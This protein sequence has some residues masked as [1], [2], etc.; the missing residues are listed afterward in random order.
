[1]PKNNIEEMDVQK[2]KEN[3]N[4]ELN[5]KR[6][7][8]EKQSK[9]P[10][11]KVQNVSNFPTSSYTFFC[12]SFGLLI[13]G[14]QATG[15]CEYGST[16]VNSVMLF[17]GICQ[18]ILGIFDW[19]QKKNILSMQNIIFGIYFISYFF[20][21]FEINGIKKS[22]VMYSYMQGL[23]DLIMLFFVSMVIL[24]IKGKGICYIIDYF[25]LFFCFACLALCGYSNDESIVI[26][27]SGYIWFISF[28]FFWITGLGLIINDTFNK[29]IIGFVEPRIQ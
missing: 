15:W 1:M 28:I 17:L 4:L 24:V 11:L 21:I 10:I 23:I 8:L 9:L 25:L 20:N 3:N 14:C 5:E 13:L 26:K 29:N 7:N 18:Y 6:T 2:K 16:F 22:K 19:Y 12:I 27:I